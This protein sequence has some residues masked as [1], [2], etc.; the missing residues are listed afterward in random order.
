MRRTDVLPPSQDRERPPKRW[1]GRGVPG[2]FLDQQ[3]FKD[4][5]RRVEAEPEP[6][7][8][9]DSE[10]Q[11]AFRTSIDASQS[12]QWLDLRLKAR[13]GSDDTHPSLSDRLAAL[14]E[15]PHVDSA[16]TTRAANAFFG[17]ALLGFIARLDSEWKESIAASWRERHENVREI[18]ASWRIWNLRPQ[19]SL[20][21]WSN[22]G[23][24]PLGL[25]KWERQRMPCRSTRRCSGLIPAMLRRSLPWASAASSRAARRH[26]LD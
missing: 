12:Q 18:R 7:S 22:P 26:S 1:F 17:G 3:F 6:Q 9:P 14:G 19:W 15:G 13:T 4:L 5:Y 24:G 8:A 11:L 23:R 2:S 10:M 20:S 25:R 16:L 21:P